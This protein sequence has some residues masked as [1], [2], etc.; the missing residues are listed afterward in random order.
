MLLNRMFRTKQNTQ[1]ANGIAAI[2]TVL[3]ATGAVFVMSAQANVG[4]E[5]TPKRLLSSPGMRQ[6]ILLP[7]ACL[8]LYGVSTIN[9][10]ILYSPKS[11]AKSAVTYGMII[12][13][14]LLVAVLFLGTEINHAR[15]WF[16]IPLGPLSISFQPS[17]FAK[18]VMVFFLAAFC[19]KY[20]QNEILPLK[21]FVIICAI[22]VVIAGLII[23]EDFGT[24][25][26]VALLAF[27]MLIIAGAK[28]RYLLPPV[29][30]GLLLFAVAIMA[31]EARK[32][33]IL[34]FLHPDRWTDSINYQP[35]QSLI[36]IGSGGAFGKGLG[37][38][39]SKY[40]HLPEDTTDFIFAIIGEELGFVGCAAVIFLFILLILLG[41]VVI[42]RTKDKFGR[43]LAAGIVFAIGLQ[44]ALNIG[45]V[46]VVL[47]T[48]GI[49][50]PFISAGGTSMLLSAAAAGVL[51]NIARQTEKSTAEIL[52]L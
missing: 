24:A 1:L 39:I 45:V 7:I 8:V 52:P 11:W 14:I 25:A 50:L 26:L 37:Q 10:K 19:H 29:P 35:Y 9:Y 36:A 31:S 32:Q 17:E 18:W 28:W 5:L 20:T 48:K 23:I 44:A 2:V 6:M 47:P 30:I 21:H 40:G 33:R 13:V 15:R 46:T 22:V 51:V 27:L 12:A 34:A 16:R 43:L 38:G 49:P 3:M 42:L 41:I 4:Q